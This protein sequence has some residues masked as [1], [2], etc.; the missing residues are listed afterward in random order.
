MDFITYSIEQAHLGFQGGFGLALGGSTIYTHTHTHTHRKMLLDGVRLSNSPPN[1]HSSSIANYSRLQTARHPP[2]SEPITVTSP[3]S[4][5][6]ETVTR[7]WTFFFFF[8]F[9]AG[10]CRDSAAASGRGR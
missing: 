7:P 1:T 5:S 2:R 10:L 6:P 4:Q 9:L 8:T 3:G